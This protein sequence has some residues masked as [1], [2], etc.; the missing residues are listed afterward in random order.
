MEFFRLCCERQWMKR[1]RILEF[2]EKKK[3][4]VVYAGGWSAA[5][6]LE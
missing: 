4:D 2:E 3:S 6:K 5:S 1:G